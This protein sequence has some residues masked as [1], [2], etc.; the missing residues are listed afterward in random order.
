MS[1]SKD[2]FNDISKHFFLKSEVSDNEIEFFKKVGINYLSKIMEQ[3]CGN[4]L[5]QLS[6]AKNIKCK[7]FGIDINEEYIK[8]AINSAKKQQIRAE[9]SAQDITNSKCIG[10][11]QYVINWNTSWPYF[12]DGETN[13]NVLSHAYMHLKKNGK[14]I[15]ELYNSEFV[16]NNFKKIRIENRNIDGVDYTCEKISS[17]ENDILKTQC[18][19]KD[20]LGNIL[21]DQT[22]S[23]KMY[24]RD[25]VIK[26]LEEVGFSNINCYSGLNLEE[27]DSE[28][29]RIIFVSEKT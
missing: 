17:I 9:F 16:K 13:I 2:F 8:D 14:Y 1:W 15:L 11:F 10:I 12:S 3:C 23:T 29:H 19:I 18:V 21:F 7:T 25:E 27:Y 4:G 20:S 26:M 24:K 22:G 28:N 5:L 6:L